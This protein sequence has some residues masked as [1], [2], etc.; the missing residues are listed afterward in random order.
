MELTV[1]IQLI[2]GVL[3]LTFDLLSYRLAYYA[4][5]RRATFGACVAGLVVVSAL[6]GGDLLIASLWA[7]DVIVN[8]AIIHKQRGQAIS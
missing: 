2:A 4:S 5:A 7:G 3:A 1:W 8:L 6:V